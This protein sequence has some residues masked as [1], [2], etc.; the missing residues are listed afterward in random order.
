[1]A[2]LF[3]SEMTEQKYVASKAFTRRLEYR[4]D[5]IAQFEKDKLATKYVKLAN[6]LGR[7]PKPEEFEDFDDLMATFGSEQRI[8]RLLLSKIDREAYEGSRAERRKR[9]ARLP[10][11]AQACRGSPRR[12]TRALPVP[13]QAD[14]KAHLGQLRASAEDGTEFLFSLGRPESMKIAC[15]ASTVGK[16]PAR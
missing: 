13:V 16:L 12:H 2:Y 7:V 5:L 3:K 10:C 9:H 6:E 11:P 1:V 4:T 14:V 15:T 8:E